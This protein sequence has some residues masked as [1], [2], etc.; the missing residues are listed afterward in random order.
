MS[1]IDETVII[2]SGKKILLVIFAAIFIVLLGVWMFSIDAEF[3]L[4]FRRLNNPLFVH[5]FGAILA[6]FGGLCGLYAIYRLCGDRRGLVFGSAGIVGYINSVGF[7]PWHEIEG[8]KI[9]NIHAQWLLAINLKEPEKFLRRQSWVRRALLN[10]NQGFCGTPAALP[11]NT[12]KASPTKLL[13]CFDR[14]KQK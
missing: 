6:I 10:S 11:I 2:L 9:I 13:A 5:T 4:T 1:D 7:I 3:V 12:L 8:A 14:Y